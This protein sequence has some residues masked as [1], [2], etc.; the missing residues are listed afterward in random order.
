VISLF[1]FF[2]RSLVASSAQDLRRLHISFT[3]TLFDFPSVAVGSC[4]PYA[5]RTC[6]LRLFLPGEKQLVWRDGIYEL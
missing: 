3:C 2:S 5:V 4:T 6:R 1:I